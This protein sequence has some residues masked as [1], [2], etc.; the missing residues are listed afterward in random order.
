MRDCST[1]K[2][3]H[4]S[5][6]KFESHNNR[7]IAL[8]TV[9]LIITI[10]FA[11]AIELNRSSRA[12]VYDATNISDGIK[13][14]YIAK[15]GFYAG[16]ALI[17]NSSGNYITLQDDWA[18]AE[19]LSAKSPGLFDDG[20]FIVTTEDES[21]KIP[22]NKLLN[23]SEFN[24]NIRAIF[25]RLLA[26]PEFDLGAGNATAIVD[27]IKAY[28]LV[29]TTP[30]DCIEELLMV[31]GVSKELFAGTKDKP[32]LVQYVTVYG[33]GL[34]NI[35][36][37]SKIVLRSLAD[38]VTVAMA[39]KM[40]EYR[41]KEGNDLSNVSWFTQFPGFSIDTITAGLIKVNSSY[42]K[43]VAAGTMSNM[44]QTVSGVVWKK[45]ANSK[46]IQIVTWRLE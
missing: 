15:S 23:G 10:L 14:I 24:P 34:I 26:Q 9:L 29:K 28:I 38:N 32:G 12:E 17:A 6:L 44:T 2:F 35:N 18:K 21:G 40:D 19:L 11:V 25:I 41:K 33:D 3:Q 36:T 13:L 42:F 7:G 37:A 27:A 31:K 30:L 8:I 5:F 46:S 20:A 1:Y 22:L 16:A 43:L 4:N 39:D 45:P